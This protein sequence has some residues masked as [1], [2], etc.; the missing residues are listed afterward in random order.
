MIEAR[1]RELLMIHHKIR[2]K[3]DEKKMKL[4]LKSGDNNKR[5]SFS[6]SHVKI[7]L[8][9]MK[10]CLNKFVSA[11][12][13]TTQNVKTRKNFKFVLRISALRMELFVLTVKLMCLLVLKREWERELLQNKIVI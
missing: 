11:S 12:S 10:K 2:R 9:L 3:R 4:L 13:T 6:V 7:I 1:A 5:R 8:E